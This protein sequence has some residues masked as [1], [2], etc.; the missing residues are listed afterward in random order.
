M[1]KDICELYV[2]LTLLEIQEEQIKVSEKEKEEIA[3]G[4]I[5][6]ANLRIR[7]LPISFTE[8]AIMSIVLLTQGV[9]GKQIVA[10]V[11]LLTEYEGKE[12]TM[13]TLSEMYPYGMYKEEVF[14]DYID[15]YLKPNKVKWS[16]LYGNE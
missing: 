1:D 14:M 16:E 13:R 5:I 8:N 11:D 4:G 9:P 15:N 3:G 6:R 12:I 7:N 2:H 10:L